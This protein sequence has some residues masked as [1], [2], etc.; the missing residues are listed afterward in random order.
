MKILSDKKS[1]RLWFL[2]SFKQKFKEKGIIVMFSEL[3]SADLGFWLCV[4]LT[5]KYL[6]GFGFNENIFKIFPVMA[7][8]YARAT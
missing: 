6:S 5:P 3:L 7:Q 2:S 4:E 1:T 8:R